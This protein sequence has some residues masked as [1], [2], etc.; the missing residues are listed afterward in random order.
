MRSCWVSVS[1]FIYTQLYIK[2]DRLR[3]VDHRRQAPRH[4]LG[5]LCTFYNKPEPCI[6]LGVW[7][8]EIRFL[9]LWTMDHPQL[10]ICVVFPHVNTIQPYNFSVAFVQR[11]TDT[12]QGT[13][14]TR[15]SIFFPSSLTFILSLKTV[16]PKRAV[17]NF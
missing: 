13:R 15:F 1:L 2:I 11:Y 5:P 7:L 8:T 16:R 4:R 6:W 9:N 14:K 17:F 10:V 12:R 3:A